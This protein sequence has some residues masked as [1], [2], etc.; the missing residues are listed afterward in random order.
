[1]N[2]DSRLE[3]S[4]T[5]NAIAE[6]ARWAT[7][8]FER[9]NRGVLVALTTFPSWKVSA[10]GRLR[11]E[12]ANL[13][14]ST[15]LFE[16]LREANPE[17][18][19][20]AITAISQD[21]Q[22]SPWLGGLVGTVQSQMMFDAE[23][24]LN[25]CV[26]AQLL[27]D[28]QFHFNL[29]AV[30]RRFDEILDGVSGQFINAT[31]LIPIPGIK[32]ENE[33]IVELW[34][35]VRLRKFSNYQFELC[36]NAGVIRPTYARFPIIEADLGFGCE[37]TIKIPTVKLRAGS[38]IT[39]SLNMDRNQRKFGEPTWWAI[40]ELVDD[41]LFVLRLA[42][43]PAIN[44]PGAILSS[45]SVH[46]E[47]SMWIQKPV[48]QNFIG[49]CLIGKG[50]S[51][52]AQL[53]W[54]ALARSQQKRKL[55]RICVRRFNAVGERSNVEDKLADL[56]IAAEALFLHDI[57]EG[58]RTELGY[59]LSLRAAR[60]LS[61]VGYQPR[62]VYVAFKRAYD[63]R[64][65]VVHGGVLPEKVKLLGEEIS[66]VEFVAKLIVMMKDALSHASIEYSRRDDFSTNEYWDELIFTSLEE[67]SELPVSE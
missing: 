50:V 25:S 51:E 45:T 62:S 35:G 20:S 21:Q 43:S 24:I 39:S 16:V 4:S 5:W 64:S 9:E 55:P 46:G 26:G 19:R 32:F 47:S 57:G 13:A 10:D 11:F 61:F 18:Y 36:A 60:L 42:V 52:R 66:T 56:M 3:D 58:N 59:R 8:D 27:S 6:Y 54:S 1:M 67:R 2:K 40:D 7:Q 29:E 48:T 65:K 31:L 30:R 41:I 15:R 37:V 63:L 23:M 28:G 38:Q 44:S 34:D 17:L 49:E 12:S 33:S 14:F 22:L 53:V